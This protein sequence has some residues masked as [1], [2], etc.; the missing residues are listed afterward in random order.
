LALGTEYFASIIQ[1][2]S[3]RTTGATVCEGCSQPVC[4]TL[5]RVEISHGTDPN[6]IETVLTGSSSVTWQ[7]SGDNPPPC[8]AT[9]TCKET[10]GGIKSLYR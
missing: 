3:G 1:F 8:G 10:W 4:L 5:E 2:N 7:G 9:A 6:W